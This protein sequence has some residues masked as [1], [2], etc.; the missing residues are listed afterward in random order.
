MNL[1][2]RKV[3]K[4]FY[5]LFINYYKVV[6][7]NY[8]ILLKPPLTELSQNAHFTAKTHKIK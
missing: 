2:N 6:K 5:R 1:F 4:P 7:G 3:Y 8:L